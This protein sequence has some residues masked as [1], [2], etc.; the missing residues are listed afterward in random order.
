[1]HY[2]SCFGW[3]CRVD[4]MKLA[5]RIALRHTR[6]LDDAVFPYF[7]EWTRCARRDFARPKYLIAEILQTVRGVYGTSMVRTSCDC[8]RIFSGMR[9]VSVYMTTSAGIRQLR[10]SAG[11][12]SVGCGR[13]CHLRHSHIL[14]VMR[15]RRSTS[16][17]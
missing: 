2:R 4:T 16:S 12:K 6:V 13:T 9:G 14:K 3:R 1:M 5:D 11:R 15:D 17:T 8:R 10:P 7:A